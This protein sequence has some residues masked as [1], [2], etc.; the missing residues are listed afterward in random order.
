MKGI[1]TTARD[2][3]E[4]KRLEEESSKQSIALLKTTNLL[5]DVLKSSIA[6]SI[7]AQ[8]LEGTT[9]LW[10]E[11]AKRNYGYTAD[12]MVGKKNLYI[13]N[14]PEDIQSGLAK[15]MLDEALK[16]G[17]SDG[18]VEHIR[19]NGGRFPA[20]YSVTTRRDEEGRPV[21]YV[22]ISKD[23]TV[24]KQQEQELREQ[25]SYN[26]SLFESSIDVLIA[27][28]TLGIITDANKQM[29]ALTGYTLQELVGTEFKDYFTN[30]KQAENCIRNVL[31]DEIVKNYE[32]TIKAKD[33]KETVMSCNATTFKGTDKTLRGV[34]AV[35][36]DITEQKRL[37]EESSLQNRKLNEATGFLN[38]VLESSTAYSIIAEDL[39]GN[40][41]AWNE[42]ARINYGYTAE[43]MVGKQNTRIL[44]APEDIA[45]GRLQ[46]VLDSALKTGKEEGVLESVRKN[47]ER[48]TASLALT[49][50]KDANGNPV[51]YVL[52]SKD[53]TNQ[54]REEVLVTK[55]VELIKQNQMSQEANRLKS[56]FLANMSHELRSPLNG[57]IGFAELMHL[58]KVGPVSPEHKEY[59]GDILSSSRHLLQL[60]NDILDL[61]KVESGKMEFHP[62]TI[63]INQVITEVCDILRTLIAKSKI[64][65]SIDVDPHINKIII[66]PAKLK[67]VLYNY[68]SNAIKFTQDEGT[69]AIRVSPEGA[70]FFRLEVEDS[71][72]GISEKD[73]P[74]LFAEFQQLDSSLNKKYQGTGLG[75]A[76][77][78]RIAEALGGEVG[79]KSV[80]AKGSTFY[81]ILPREP[82]KIAPK[83]SVNTSPGS[84]PEELT[85]ASSIDPIKPSPNLP[86]SLISNEETVTLNQLTTDPIVKSP[87]VLVI[88]DN[89]EDSQLIVNALTDEGYAVEV[90]FNGAEA[91]KLANKKHFD[92]I[93]LDLLLPDMNG[94]EVLRALRAKGSN[95]ETP[96]IVVTVVVSKAISFG[97][98][99]QNFL[100]KPI[101][102]EDLIIALEQTDV[103]P[104][105][106]KTILFV[107]DDPQMLALCKQYLRDHGSVIFCESDAEKALT[108][109]NIKHPDVI[110]LDLLMPEMDGLEFLRRF[111]CTEYGKNTPVIICT[112]QDMGDI[113][114]R[115]LKASV[116]AVV[117]KGGG[118]MTNLL[119]EIKRICPT[120]V[121]SE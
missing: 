69:I 113:D 97:F 112:S 52:I 104:N 56:E 20:M 118:S 37:E 71:G 107:D 83:L 10:N 114:R 4:Q 53:I 72:I 102:S 15:E 5:N 2:I 94:W 16:T 23:I 95:L 28:D 44:H 27:T 73:I 81:I 25:L 86:T 88:E 30:H 47:G 14:T 17:S 32:L 48:F 65:L 41:L 110:I 66:D 119:T 57:I 8:D 9:L 24:Q 54:K 103:H 19:K 21:G 31:A 67:Q 50:R 13:L 101:K 40:I 80:V 42:G 77:T 89:P 12:D 121:R 6:Y 117:Q 18:V 78:R 45:S 82:N 68:I 64:H 105:E 58:G 109:A 106:N 79:V 76:L 93:T 26:R 7:I 116:A 38:N 111:R 55:N 60:I 34:F 62:E 11:G 36:R 35:A 3:T 39:E 108:L 43:E 61:A 22:I 85:I 90:A 115:R 51:G 84:T 98:M 63:D 59:L 46:T 49:L 29:S 120:S 70:D 96:S 100:T 74:K 92:L 99:I 1:F 87:L 33:G 91:I 75:L